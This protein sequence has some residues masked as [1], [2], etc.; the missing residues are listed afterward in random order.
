MEASGLGCCSTARRTASNMEELRCG[1]NSLASTIR[2]TIEVINLRLEHF[3]FR[4]QAR[5]L[6]QD[7]RYGEMLNDGTR[8]K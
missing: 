2:R 8:L 3:D 5:C 1:S 4:I 7:S 6:D